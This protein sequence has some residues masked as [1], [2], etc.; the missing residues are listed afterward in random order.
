MDASDMVTVGEPLPLIASA[1]AAAAYGLVIEWGSGTRKGSVETVDLSPLILHLKLYTPLRSDRE[2]LETVHV[3]GDGA[4][5]ARGSND[6]IDMPATAI[7][8]L[9]EAIVQ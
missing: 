4:A 8:R 6:E 3:M 5:V 7:W 1:K 2:L 9:A